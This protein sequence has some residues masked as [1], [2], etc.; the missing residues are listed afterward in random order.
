VL[1]DALESGD[2]SDRATAL[3]GLA[4]LMPTT[5]GFA[6]D[7]PEPARVEAAARAREWSIAR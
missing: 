2:P 1:L 7:D 4:P 5:M 6:P 3:L